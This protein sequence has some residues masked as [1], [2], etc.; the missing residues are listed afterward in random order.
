MDDEAQ[1]A[2]FQKMSRTLGQWKSL[3]ELRWDALGENLSIRFQAG[4]DGGPTVTR[5]WAVPLELAT[6]L[7]SWLG[8]ALA[9][10][11]AAAQPMQ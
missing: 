8:Q 11:A 4:P 5:D 3:D 1:E 7:H 6:K 10:R 9:E 2:S